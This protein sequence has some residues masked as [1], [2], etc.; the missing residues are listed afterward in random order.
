ME[1]REQ[2]ARLTQQG[3]TAR[4]SWLIRKGLIGLVRMYQAT[5]PYRPRV[6]RYYPSCSEYMIQAIEKYGVYT[7]VALGLRRIVRCNP[8]SIGGYDPVP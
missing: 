3:L 4:M 2:E 5:R 7:G 1:E 6:C 8:L